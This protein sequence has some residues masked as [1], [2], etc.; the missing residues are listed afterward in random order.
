MAIVFGG[1]LGLFVIA[2][3]LAATLFRKC[4]K[5]GRQVCSVLLAWLI[6]TVLAAYGMAN[7]EEPDFISSALIYGA[8][9]IILLAIYLGV[10]FA[11]EL[12]AEQGGTDRDKCS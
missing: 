10:Y 5:P 1:V 12:M 6:A 11:R 8:A 2:S 9:A 4:N 3:L 7:G